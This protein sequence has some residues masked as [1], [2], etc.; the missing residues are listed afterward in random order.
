MAM[1]QSAMMELGTGAPEF[2]LTD[3]VSGQEMRLSDLRGEKGVL[4]MFI[5]N[6]C[7]FVVHI[8]KALSALGKDYHD[9]GMGIAAISANDVA[10]YPDDSPDK[11]K[12]TAKR[13]GYTFPYLY[14]ETQKVARAYGAECTPDFFLFD[15]EL[16]CA[17]RG[18]FDDSR[19]GNSKPV[20]GAD[21]R[22]A[23]DLLIAGESVPASPQLPSIGC[24]IK[25]KS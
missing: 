1:I 8:Q 13:E 24:S 10:N 15:G 9:S 12:A 5:C 21:I 3:T 14:D 6:H 25:W 19:P 2:T 18:R 4:I 7:P 23:M 20:T 22:G 11:M 17:Y 16:K